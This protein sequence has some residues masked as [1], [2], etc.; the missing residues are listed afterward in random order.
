MLCWKLK[1]RE[2]C[3][4]PS[5]LGMALCWWAAS[6]PGWGSCTSSCHLGLSP[7]FLKLSQLAALAW[8]ESVGLWTCPQLH[9]KGCIRPGHEMCHSSMMVKALK[10]LLHILKRTQWLTITCIYTSSAFPELFH[11]FFSSHFII[12]LLFLNFK[13][14][15]SLRMYPRSSCSR[16]VWGSTHPPKPRLPILYL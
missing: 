3:V 14:P 1:A 2:A 10:I 16:D 5:A 7:P 13:P 15:T 6:Q 8:P 12:L 11:F 4:R 9:W